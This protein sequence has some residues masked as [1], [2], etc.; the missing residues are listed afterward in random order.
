MG[1]ILIRHRKLRRKEAANVDRITG[2]IK[3]LLGLR[4]EGLREYPGIRKS[5]GGG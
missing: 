4:R 1:M 2:Q 5:G 3:M